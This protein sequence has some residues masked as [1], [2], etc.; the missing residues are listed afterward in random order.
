MPQT[1]T[2][3]KIGSLLAQRSATASSIPK[4]RNMVAFHEAG[5]AIV[6]LVLSDSGQFE[7]VTIIPHTRW[8][9]CDHAAKDDQ[10]LPR[11]N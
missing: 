6:G 9:L 5:H 10:F 7:K 4:E 1:W 11:R 2:K 8:R 3:P